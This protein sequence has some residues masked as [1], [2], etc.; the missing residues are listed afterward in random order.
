MPDNQNSK[1]KIVYLNVITLM[2]M[3]TAGNLI[4]LAVDETGMLTGLALTFLY[5]CIEVL[6]TAIVR[7]TIII[8]KINDDTDVFGRRI[9]SGLE[10]VKEKIDGKTKSGDSVRPE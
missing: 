1:Y 10:H 2:R 3:L 8:N 5:I 7:L 6:M 4:Y 9:L